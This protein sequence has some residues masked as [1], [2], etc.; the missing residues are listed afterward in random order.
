MTDLITEQASPE[1]ANPV[2]APEAAPQTEVP[3]EVGEVAAAGAEVT[4]IPVAEDTS[5]NGPVDV[6]AA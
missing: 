3:Q 6:H 4:Q 5:D 1:Q 2:A